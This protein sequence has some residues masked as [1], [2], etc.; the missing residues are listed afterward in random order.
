MIDNYNNI[1][2]VLNEIRNALISF[3]KEG[4]AYTLYMEK[5]GLRDEEQVEVLETLGK[6]HVTIEF[7]ETDQPV[8]WYETNFSGIW[9]GTFKNGQDA[10]ILHTVEVGVYPA[11]AR[12]YPED[13]DDAI[14]DLKV[15]ID[16][17]GL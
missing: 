10:N 7:N 5:S 1:R 12:S 6:G 15:W 8:T 4:K 11:L 16:A 13:M 9:V 2:A 17:A 14:D 3:R